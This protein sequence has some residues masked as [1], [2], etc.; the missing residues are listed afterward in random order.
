[1][2]MGLSAG[3]ERCRKSHPL[4]DSIPRPSSCAILAPQH[5]C[6][7]GNNMEHWWLCTDRWK[8]KYWEKNL[9]QCHFVH[10]K[11]HMDWPVVEPGLLQW[12]AGNWQHKTWHSSWVPIEKGKV[13]LQLFSWS[14]VA[15]V[16][17]PQTYMGLLLKGVCVHWAKLNVCVA[18]AKA[19]WSSYM[20]EWV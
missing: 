19:G 11:S 5:P 13:R 3:L 16:A 20:S 14:C 2:G 1:M 9:L 7:C 17:L 4:Q 18:I 12:K 10:H 6:R 15:A 8:L